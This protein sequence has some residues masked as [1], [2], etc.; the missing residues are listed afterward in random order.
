MILQLTI[1]NR[2]LKCATVS[3]PLYYPS[4]LKIEEGEIDEARLILVSADY[5]HLTH[6]N[7]CA[8]C[9]L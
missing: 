8:I 1:V 2:F 7:E 5:V 9:H 3:V 4:Y 6:S